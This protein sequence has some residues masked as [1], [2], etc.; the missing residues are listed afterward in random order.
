MT[1]NDRKKINN[2]W[3]FLNKEMHHPPKVLN[4]ENIVNPKIN[5]K[6]AFVTL[7]EFSIN[8]IH[9]NQ[10]EESSSLKSM[11]KTHFY[12]HIKIL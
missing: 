5:L 11:R 10:L 3:F 6:K 7:T 2:Y 4:E 8:I 1:S 12:L 9:T